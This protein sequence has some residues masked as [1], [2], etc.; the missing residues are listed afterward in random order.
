MKPF[1]FD[2][3]EETEEDGEKQ[4]REEDEL[5]AACDGE[6]MRECSVLSRDRIDKRDADI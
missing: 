5:I 2:E 4:E 3:E 1:S 6:L